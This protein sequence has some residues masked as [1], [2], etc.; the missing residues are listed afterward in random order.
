MTLSKYAYCFCI[1]VLAYANLSFYPKWEKGGTEA[2]LSW[3]VCGYYYYL[4]AIFIYKDLNKVAFHTELDKKYQYQGDGFYSA[5]PS[6]NGNLIMKY[7]AGMAVMYA[8]AFFVAHVLAKPLGFEADGFSPI[9]QFAISFWS[10]LWA[11]VGL[12]YLRKL[13]LKLNFSE[14]VTATVLILYVLSTN[15]LEYAGISSPQAHSYIFTLYSIM[16]FQII[17]FYEAPSRLHRD[18]SVKKALSIGLCMGLAILARPTEMITVMIPVLWGVFDKNSLVER[19]NFVKNHFSKYLL[20]GS[21]VVVLGM[22]QV[23]YW[24][25]TAGYFIYDSYGKTDFMEWKRP[26]ILDGLFSARRGW[27]VYSPIF[28]FAIVGFWQ[29][30]KQ[31][32]S[33]FINL[34]AFFILFVYVSF[35]HNIW[36]YGGGL[37]QRQMI[38]IYPMLAIPLAAF[39]TA[40]SQN[41]TRQIIF[42]VAASVCIYLNLWLTYQGH[43]G[44][45]WR[46]D[47]TPAYL[48]RIIGR[49]DVPIDAQKL[50][51]NKYDF[52][53]E[54]KDVA[55]IYENNFELDTSQNIDLQTFINDKRSLFVESTHPMTTHYEIPP[56]SIK[57][58]KWL[59]ATA[60]FRSTTR[61]WTDWKMPC[62]VVD[63]QE[64][65]ESV[66]YFV[67]RP[68][69][70]MEKENEQKTLWLDIKIPSKSFDQIKFWLQ[71]PDSD[72]K[73][74]MDDIKFE[75]F[76]D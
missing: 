16:L 35:S 41:L 9:Y 15:Y 31:H 7:S 42:G 17:R 37:S 59:R 76:N 18:K 67:L 45:L 53:G 65:G 19:I 5:L 4:P 71:S 28:L 69:R 51:D 11:F 75:A 20:A 54:Q 30:K 64:K 27:L 66:K 72:K 68:H 3:D 38:Q 50:L 63:F 61:E 55:V 33:L 74:M 25:T 34:L 2:A 29:L 57:D 56:L 70:V 48:R 49:W 58:K 73:I 32:K 6:V 47:V 1:A 44:G 52:T 36:W 13:L 8:P 23:I 26:H 22:I 39:L 62:L 43:Q 46:D 40:V 60:I 21:V 12:W 24:K 14:S 10:V